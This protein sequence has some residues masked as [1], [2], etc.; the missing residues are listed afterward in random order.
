[1]EEHRFTCPTHVREFTRYRA[2]VDFSQDRPTDAP[3]S[4]EDPDL[5]PA[6]FAEDPRAPAEP[7]RLAAR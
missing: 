3:V 1:M 4:R 6:A 7:D 5:G 2:H